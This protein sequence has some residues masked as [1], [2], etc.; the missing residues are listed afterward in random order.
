MEEE[1]KVQNVGEFKCIRELKTSNRLKIILVRDKDGLLFLATYLNRKKLLAHYKASIHDSNEELSLE[2][3]EEKALEKYKQTVEEFRAMY[4]RVKDLSHPGLAEV[5]QMI[6]DDEQDI[7]VIIS[8]YVPG[9]SL[10]EAAIGLTPKQMLAVFVRIFEIIKFLHRQGLLILNLKSSSFRINLESEE[11]V[12]KLMNCGFAIL[13]GEYTGTIR[14]PDLTMPPEVAFG[15]RDKID[16]RAD[17]YIMASLMYRC[18][19][20]KYP[21]PERRAAKRDLKK[22]Q[23][24]IEREGEPAE[25]SNFR[26]DVPD[27]MQQLLFTLLKKNPD[28]REEFNTATKAINYFYE[29]WPNDSKE[30]AVEHT[31]TTSESQSKDDDDEDDTDE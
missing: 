31:I 28:E 16:E 20:N 1:K 13:K 15:Q 8:E 24:R 19:T 11:P 3:V 27:G 12:I 26:N 23:N 6:H 18:I 25:L 21:Y 4:N 17:L 22:L 9:Q 14:G 29:K 2:E 5:Y 7:D 10:F 30:L